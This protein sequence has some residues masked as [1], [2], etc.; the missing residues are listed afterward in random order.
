MEEGE[1]DGEEGE[2]GEE[3]KLFTCTCLGGFTLP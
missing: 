3:E 1:G 2:K